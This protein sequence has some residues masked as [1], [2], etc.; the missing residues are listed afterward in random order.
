MM[1]RQE[2]C[3][4]TKYVGVQLCLFLSLVR[5]TEM[6]QRPLPFVLTKE[7]VDDWTD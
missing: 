2:Y 7:E 6:E 1:Q 3:N 4:Y 5:R